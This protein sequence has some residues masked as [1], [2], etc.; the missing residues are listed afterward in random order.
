MA[1]GE[2]DLKRKSIED[3]LVKLFTTKVPTMN[4]ADA[5]TLSA[6]VA[7]S[8]FAAGILIPDEEWVKFGQGSIT[9]VLWQLTRLWML[10]P[11]T[12]RE[13]DPRP[14]LLVPLH[15]DAQEGQ[16]RRAHV[17]R[18]RQEGGLGNLLQDQQGNGGVQAQEG[19]R[20]PEQP[21]RDRHE[22]GGV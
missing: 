6:I 15:E 19:D 8:M 3:G 1:E 11:E 21:P 4:V 10:C 9:G 12:A 7:D 2:P 16:P 14:V 18:I 20:A 17:G 13:R 22:R 5:E